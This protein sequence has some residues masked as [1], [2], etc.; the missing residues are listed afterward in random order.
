VIPL[1]EVATLSADGLLD[2][3]KIAAETLDLG[4]YNALLHSPVASQRMN[5]VQYVHMTG[6]RSPG[7]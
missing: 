5:G 4:S 3:Q 1:P 6:L 2:G 7:N